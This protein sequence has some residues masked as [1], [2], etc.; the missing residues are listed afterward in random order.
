LIGDTIHMQVPSEDPAI[1]VFSRIRGSAEL[2]EPGAGWEKALLEEAEEYAVS[3][4]VKTAA[5]G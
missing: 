4:W 5:V 2:P 3:V 1:Q